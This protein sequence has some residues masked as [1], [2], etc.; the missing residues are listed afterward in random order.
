MCVQVL[1]ARGEAL[2]RFLRDSM[3]RLGVASLDSETVRMKSKKADSS[4]ESR[5]LVTPPPGAHVS[6]EEEERVAR[7]AGR[8][9]AVRVHSEAFRKW[10]TR[11]GAIVL[12]WWWG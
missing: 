6:H 11:F 9:K 10:L 1:L 8:P 7:I 12:A 2:V 3:N 5:V 4:D